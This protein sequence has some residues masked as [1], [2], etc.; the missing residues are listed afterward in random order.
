MCCTITVPGAL[1]G[2]RIST[3]RMASVP[4]VDAPMA[5]ILC[6]VWA[7]DIVAGLGA[8]AAGVSQRLAAGSAIAARRDR[9]EAEIVRRVPGTRVAGAGAPRLPNTAALV[10]EGAEGR[11]IAAG[12]DARGLAVSAGSACHSGA[13]EPSPVTRA[14]GFEPAFQRGLVRVSLGP[15]TGDEDLARAS[16]IL[17]DAA[18]EAT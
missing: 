3:S 5:I 4:P 8:A 2:N 1:A 15:E 9:F 17:V 11:A 16:E 10:F 14:L 18:R 6:V 13:G 12:C 7:I